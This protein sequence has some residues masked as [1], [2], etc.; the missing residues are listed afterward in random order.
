VMG[1]MTARLEIS[2][3]GPQW[4]SAVLEQF[5]NV[6]VLSAAGSTSTPLLDRW[7]TENKTGGYAFRLELLCSI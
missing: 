3:H 6:Q 2:P 4:M 5:E 7:V 1:Q